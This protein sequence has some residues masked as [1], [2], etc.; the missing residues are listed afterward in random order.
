[1]GKQ[2]KPRSKKSWTF[3]HTNQETRET[4]RFR[5]MANGT[6]KTEKFLGWRT[7][8]GKIIPPRGK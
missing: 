5:K 6:I 8:K 7:P 4:Y 3:V 2:P 1:M